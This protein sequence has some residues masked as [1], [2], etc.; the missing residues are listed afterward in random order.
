MLLGGF[1][2]GLSGDGEGHA[3][4][5]TVTGWKKYEKL[6]ETN[7]NSR[8]AFVAMSFDPELKYIFDKAI[9]PACSECGFSGERVDS[10]EHNEKICDRIIA[11]INESR[12]MIADFT[13]NKHGVYFE[14]GYAMGLGIPIIWTCSKEF[15]E[16]LQ[17]DTRQYNHI[18]WENENDLK[19]QLANRIKATIK[20]RE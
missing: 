1:I 14:A 15:K 18:I 7:I 5:L 13:Q 17:F 12:F 20:I 9:F 16:D 10:R 6:K 11:K 2:R 19:E 4:L 3:F 8:I